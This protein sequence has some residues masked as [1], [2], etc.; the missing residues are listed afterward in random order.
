MR[1]GQGE[2]QTQSQA[3]FESPGHFQ[4]PANYWKGLHDGLLIPWRQLRLIRETDRIIGVSTDTTRMKLFERGGSSSC[5][6]EEGISG[7]PFIIEASRCLQIVNTSTKKPIKRL[8]ACA[9]AY[10]FTNRLINLPTLVYPI[11]CPLQL[12]KSEGQRSVQNWMD[13]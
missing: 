6:E 5:A 12:T 9:H 10:I 7:D 2:K 3:G 11:L 8:R 4:G 1:E 13:E